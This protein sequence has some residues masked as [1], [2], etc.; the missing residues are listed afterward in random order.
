MDASV[1]ITLMTSFQMLA[2]G[3]LADLIDKRTTR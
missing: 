1:V 3:L 2:I